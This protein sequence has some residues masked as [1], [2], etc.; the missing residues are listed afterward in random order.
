MA[1]AANIVAAALRKSALILA[2]GLVVYGAITVV[3]VYM[4]E[5]GKDKDRAHDKD[6]Q[7]KDLKD[8]DKARAHDKDKQDKDHAM[9]LVKLKVENPKADI[10]ALKKEVYAIIRKNYGE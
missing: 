3:G 1:E 10:E 5:K 7:D 6:K 8:K 2:T 9:I 4:K